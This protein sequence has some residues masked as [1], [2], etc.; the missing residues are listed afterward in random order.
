M[1][2][3]LALVLALVMLMGTIFS[4][5]PAAAAEEATASA[6]YE[7][8][9]SYANINYS[10]KMYMMFAVPAPASSVGEGNTVNLLVWNGIVS[11]AYSIKDQNVEL[12]SA[13][14]D[15]VTIGEAQY[16]VFKYDG[17]TAA[18]MT[19]IISARPAIVNT[20]EETVKVEVSPEE[21][22]DAG[23]V[24]KEAVYEDKIV[25]HNDAVKY[26]DLVEYSVLEYVATAK[27]QF[28]G[29]ALADDVIAMLDSMLAFGS[30]AQKY[31][32]SKHDYLADDEL[33]KIWYV[34][35]IRGV[36]GEKVFGGFFK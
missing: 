12:L 30:L 13:E 10:D 6:S 2:K 19:K 15:K 9:I 17:L 26:G 29:A 5:I 18:D 3:N 27:G 24:I 31:S 21:K 33:S 7:P 28:G 16:L 35:V 14:A 22:N 11:E 23:E 1:K 4:V 8:K 34:P 32:G 36:V 25:V 20:W